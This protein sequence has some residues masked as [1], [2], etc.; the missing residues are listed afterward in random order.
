MNPFSKTL[1]LDSAFIARSIITSERAFVIHYKG[2]ADVLHTYDQHF[3]TVNEN[4]KF[5]IPSVVRVKKYINTPFFK[6]KLTRENVY[7]RD[8]YTCVYCG[9]NVRKFLTLDH[10]V[11]RS[12]GGQD[13]W[14]NLVTACKRCNNEKSDLTLEEYGKKIPQPYRPHYLM[15]IKKIHNIPEDWKQYLLFN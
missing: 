14:E 4:I 15:L 8:N 2:N 10:V 13:S 12:K 1:V 5:K 11:P 9:S 3:R 6:A 7:K